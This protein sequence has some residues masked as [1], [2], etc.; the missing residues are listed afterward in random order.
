MFIFSLSLFWLAKIRAGWGRTMILS[1]VC[2]FCCSRTLIPLKCQQLLRTGKIVPNSL[3]LYINGFRLLRSD[4]STILPIRSFCHLSVMRNL[5]IQNSQ[6]VLK[7]ICLAFYFCL[8]FIESWTFS[9]YLEASRWLLLKLNS[10]DTYLLIL[11]NCYWTV[12]KYIH[13]Q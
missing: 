5:S 11:K 1:T 4:S 12:V 2:A 6:T 3:R 8:I 13:F 10:H 9:W 7:I